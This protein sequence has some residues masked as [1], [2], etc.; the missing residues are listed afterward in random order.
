MNTV[1]AINGVKATSKTSYLVKIAMLS[2]IAGVLM[3]LEV[4]MPFLAPNFYKMDLSEVPVLIGA[5]A[6]GPVAGIIIEAVKVLL[7]LVINGTLTAGVGEFANFLIG[8]LLVVPAS[9]I[10]SRHKTKGTAVIGM[11]TGIFTMT[12]GAVLLNAYLLLPVYAKAFHLPVEAFINMGHAINPAIDN[13][14]TF[15]ALAVLPFNLIKG[16]VIMVIVLAIYK[17]IHHL[18]NRGFGSGK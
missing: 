5:F 16:I 14:F 15:C 4:P 9:A 18:L 8:I 2:A 12:L 10:Y 3:L 7:N 13:M 17:R 1:K 11:V 6:L